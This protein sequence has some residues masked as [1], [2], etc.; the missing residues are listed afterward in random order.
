VG[1]RV[2]TNVTAALPNA[3]FLDEAGYVVPVWRAFFQAL[4]TRTGGSVGSV[5]PPDLTDTLSGETAAREAADTTLQNNI[6]A[7]ASA[8]AAA[9]AALSTRITNET[10]ARTAAVQVETAGRI[11]GDNAEASARAAGD[12]AAHWASLDLSGL[13]TANPGSGK[14][15]LSSGN[16]RVGP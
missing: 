1:N 8:R 14:P 15:W 6:N 4:Y 10:N 5:V 7:E 13:P 12:T 2:V 11:A 9:D 3:P 16:I